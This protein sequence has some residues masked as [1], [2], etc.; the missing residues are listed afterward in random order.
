M[1]WLIFG[2]QICPFIIFIWDNKSTQRGIY[3]SVPITNDQNQGVPGNLR[4]QVRLVAEFCAKWHGLN[5]RQCGQFWASVSCPSRL[6][7]RTTISSELIWD[8]LRS[9]SVPCQSLPRSGTPLLDEDIPLLPVGQLFSVRLIVGTSEELLC[10]A[11]S[12]ANLGL[13]AE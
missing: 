6:S 11:D 5:H 2:Y 4:A 12:T 9:S 1:T 7:G 10:K 13:P 3:K 8:Q